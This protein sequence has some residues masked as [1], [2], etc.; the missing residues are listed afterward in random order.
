[1]RVGGEEKMIFD[2]LHLIKSEL[3]LIIS[4]SGIYYLISYDKCTL[5]N[6]HVHLGSLIVVKGW[7]EMANWS[8]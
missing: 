5:Y 7:S 2:W 1:M 6:T 3:N 8:G 4:I